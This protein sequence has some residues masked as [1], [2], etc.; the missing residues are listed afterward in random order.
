MAANM[1]FEDTGRYRYATQDTNIE[2]EDTD[3]LRMMRPALSVGGLFV[4]PALAYPLPTAVGL[5]GDTFDFESIVSTHWL[6]ATA[7][8]DTERRRT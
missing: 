8:R 1:D 3:I 6:A 2:N 7:R 5:R 4:S